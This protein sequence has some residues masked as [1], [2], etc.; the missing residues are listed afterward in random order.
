MNNNDEYD[1]DLDYESLAEEASSVDFQD[2]A[3]KF[4]SSSLNITNTKTLTVKFNEVKY[5]FAVQ[6]VVVSTTKTLLTVFDVETLD[7][8]GTQENV[9][10]YTDKKIMSLVEKS[11][12]N[13]LKKYNKLDTETPWSGKEAKTAVLDSF[14]HTDFKNTF[15]KN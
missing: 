5:Y 4:S 10:G 11:I 9:K 1:Y 6:L 12:K 8:I 13:H 7:S 3:K 2:L 14:K 15:F